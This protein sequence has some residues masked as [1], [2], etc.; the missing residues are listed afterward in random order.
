MHTDVNIVHACCFCQ[1]LFE[2]FHMCDKQLLLTCEVLV[3]LAILVKYVNNNDLLSGECPITSHDA[4][5][6]R[7]LET[8]MNASLSAARL[9]TIA[10]SNY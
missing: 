2:V 5:T 3:D 7:F 1:V 4:S 8:V 10:S 6:I 9:I